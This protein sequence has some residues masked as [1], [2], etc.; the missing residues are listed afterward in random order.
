M[1]PAMFVFE[2]ITQV[3]VGVRASN[4]QLGVVVDGWEEGLVRERGVHGPPH[5]T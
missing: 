1:W 5:Q 3:C 2:V 4:S